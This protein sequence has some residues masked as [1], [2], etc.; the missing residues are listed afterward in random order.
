MP[1]SAHGGRGRPVGLR[2]AAVAVALAF[3][4][5][6]ALPAVAR[7]T[8]TFTSPAPSSTSINTIALD[9]QLSEVADPHS[10]QLE[11]TYTGGSAARSAP[12]TP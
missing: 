3:G 6:V 4:L 10:V 8:V 1:G 11:L 7:A 5:V 9:Y 12:T 2:A